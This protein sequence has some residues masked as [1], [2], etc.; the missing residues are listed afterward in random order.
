MAKI[1]IIGGGPAGLALAHELSACGL[2]VSLFEAAPELGGLARSFRFGDV[3]IERY[4]HFICG[5]DTGYF[6]KLSEARDRRRA[7]VAP[8]QDGLLL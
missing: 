5:A 1:G 8:D 3:T 7:A 4:Y 2:E 6:R